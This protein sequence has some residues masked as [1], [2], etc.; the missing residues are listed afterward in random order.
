MRRNRLKNLL[1]LISDGTKGL[2]QDRWQGDV[3]LYTGMGKLGDQQL[4]SQNK[5]VAESA[6]NGIAM[7]LFEV[8]V[9][10]EYVYSGLVELCG[11]PFQE[12]QPDEEGKPRLVWIFP[13][14]RIEAESPVFHEMEAKLAGEG[15]F[16]P[17]TIEDARE[18]T[19][20]SIVRRRGRKAFRNKLIAAYRGKCAISNCGVSEL[21]DAA[22]IYPYKGSET[23]DVRNGILL[24]T[25][26]HT[27]FDLGLI[28]VDPA[29]W[30]VV[31]AKRLAETNYGQFHGRK[32]RQP[33]DSDS[34]PSA[35]AL[36]WHRK[37]A[38]L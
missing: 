37:E 30:T 1:V 35:E 7:H 23:N 22:H 33:Q 27:L 11:Q 24:R 2:Y 19:L 20:A 38:K 28:S 6:S 17:A 31:V 13:L 9:P 3:L 14:R 8:A 25:D 4:A 32:F 26:L 29:T 15:V 12:T 10:T 16:D 21:L 36:M 18:K 5:T 34:R